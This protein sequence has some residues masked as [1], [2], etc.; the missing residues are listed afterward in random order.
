MLKLAASFVADLVV[1][2]FKKMFAANRD[3]QIG[4]L[5]EANQADAIALKD[6]EKANEIKNRID[7]ASDDDADKL[8]QSLNN[9]D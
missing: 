6:A 3:E 7:T 5:K 9:R 1:G 2:I 4:V 8:R